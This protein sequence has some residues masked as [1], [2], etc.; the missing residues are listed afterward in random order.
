MI[1]YYLVF[2]MNTSYSYIR[3]L[4]SSENLFAFRMRP[5]QSN[6]QRIYLAFQKAQENIIVTRKA[7][8]YDRS[9]VEMS[10]L[11]TL[12]LPMDNVCKMSSWAYVYNV[13]EIYIRNITKA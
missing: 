2:A 8:M 7:G 6:S 9:R 13:V 4:A 12:R 3:Y 5:I 10:L 1:K 11:G